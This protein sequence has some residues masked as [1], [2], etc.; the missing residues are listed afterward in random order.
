MKVRG[1]HW[2]KGEWLPDNPQNTATVVCKVV[3]M[4]PDPPQ[5]LLLPFVMEQEASGSG[6]VKLLVSGER[7]VG[8]DPRHLPKI[9]VLQSSPVVG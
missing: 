8:S 9:G 2:R 7:G 3:A 6:L 5:G 1:C 4:S